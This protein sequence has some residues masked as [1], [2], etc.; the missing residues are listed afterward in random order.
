[1]N[2]VLQQELLRFNRL[3]S[4][5][6]GS[7]QNLRKAIK[8]LVV[9]SGELEAMITSLFNNQVPD[10]WVK[11][12]YPSLK[13]LGAYVN[14]F[15]LRLK[16]MGDWID[17]GAPPSFWISGFYFTQSFLTGTMQN[18]A[19]KYV[20]PIDTLMFDFFVIIDK[21]K[22]DVKKPAPDGVYVHGLYL[23]GAQYDMS[24]INVYIQNEDTFL[25]KILKSCSSKCQISG[26]YL[27]QMC[28]VRR[29]RKL[30]M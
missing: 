13:P 15:I 21:T 30:N 8:G 10:L 19:R 5:I 27:R 7:L 29:K 22:H 18:F 26:C 25:I 9:M 11:A 4:A 24:R 28:S 23:E 16:F 14:D 3:L 20:I 12:S 1:M 6:R 2:T 17:E